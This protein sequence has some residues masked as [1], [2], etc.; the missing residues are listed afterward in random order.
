VDADASY[1]AMS[2]DGRKSTVH[3]ASIE[4]IFLRRVFQGRFLIGTQE[5]GIMGRDV[6]NHV[7]VL[8]DG[9]R[10]VWDEQRLTSK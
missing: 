7:S 10:R 4:L 8:L 3:V 5:C 1:E 2:F 9:P 6:P